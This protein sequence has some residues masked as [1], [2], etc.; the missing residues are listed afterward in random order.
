MPAQR[1]KT[2]GRHQEI[3]GDRGRQNGEENSPEG[4]THV[5]TG[6]SRE[7]GEFDRGFSE[8]EASVS[9]F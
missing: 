9:C 8:E 7:L 6:P 4:S 1:N 3:P 5:E 2:N